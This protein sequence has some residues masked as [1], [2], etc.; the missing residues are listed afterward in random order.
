MAED[1]PSAVL[2]AC[3]ENAIRSPMAAGLMRHFYGSKVFVSSAGVRT[4]DIDPFVVAVMDEI[5][6]D[7][8]RHRPQ[9]F[10]DLEDTSFD[11][12]VSLSPEA[13]HRALEMTRTM[14]IAAEYWPTRDPSVVSG[15]REQLLDAYRA[16][17]DGLTQKI[18]SRFGSL[19][20]RGV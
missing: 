20:A 1:V 18:L 19:A 9:S 4:G 6:I 14:A 10:D 8:S 15:S 11:V 17:R 12:V 7:V 16:V 5:G 2:F 13:H 3:S